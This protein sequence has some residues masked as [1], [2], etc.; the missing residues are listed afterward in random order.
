M[1][2]DDIDDDVGDAGT[3]GDGLGKMMVMRMIEMLFLAHPD[4]SLEKLHQSSHKQVFFSFF[5][6]DASPQ[7]SR[8]S[9]G[10]RSFWPEQ[11]QAS[12]KQMV[13]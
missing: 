1:S 8:Q 11:L 5:A 13:R 2:D 3:D 6:R 9:T 7:A 12:G 10:V 4:P